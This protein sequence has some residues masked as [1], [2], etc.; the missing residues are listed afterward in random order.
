MLQ[1]GCTLRIEN[2]ILLNTDSSMKY[3]LKS[4]LCNGA[5]FCSSITLYVLS[6]TLP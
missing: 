6:L 2:K 1:D 3:W 4:T 5:M